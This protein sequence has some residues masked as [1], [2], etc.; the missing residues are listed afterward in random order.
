MRFK[1]TF[2]DPVPEER[3][4]TFAKAGIGACAFHGV[5]RFTNSNQLQVGEEILEGRHILIAAGAKPQKLNIPGEQYLTTSEQ[6]LELDSLPRRILFVGGGYISFEF[7]HVS[8]RCGADVAIL[9]RAERLLERFDL[10]WLSSLYIRH[11]SLGLMSNSVTKY[12]PLKRRMTIFKCALP[13]KVANA[14]FRP[15]W[16]CMALVALPILM[17]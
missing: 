17:N 4:K 9:H 1:R 15:I 11:A 5:A 8:V 12:K 2:T 7:A 13:V 3:E 14:Y 16:L 10:I 6:F